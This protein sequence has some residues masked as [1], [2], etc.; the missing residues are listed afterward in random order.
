MVVY[1]K[2]GEFKA[3]VLELLQGVVKGCINFRVKDNLL[4]LQMKTV[5]ITELRM[6]VLR[7][8]HYEDRNLTVEI[9]RMVEVLS[10]DE[11]LSL[12]FV[13]DMIVFEQEGFSLTASKQPVELEQLDVWDKVFKDK[14]SSYTIQCVTNDCK[15]MDDV[16]KDLAMSPAPLNIIDGVCYVKYLTMAYTQNCSLPDMM[17]SNTAAKR[18]SKLLRESEVVYDYDETRGLLEIKQDQMSA[19][20]VSTMRPDH[21]EARL[22]NELLEDIESLTVL[23]IGKYKELIEMLGRIY[24]KVLVELTI[25]K[26]GLNVAIKNLGNKQLVLGQAAT[27]LCSI[28]ITMAQL[29]AI[30]KIFGRSSEETEVLKGGNLICLRNQH[31]GKN[32]MIAGT[33][34]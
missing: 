27:P 25:C 31:Y 6:Q 1:V 21:R 34:Y 19:C 10:D 9:D 30:A 24:K 22:I 7:V 20:V 33:L 23:N 26:G 28:T 2:A 17:I 5:E 14:M 8:E 3:R 32:L 16:A 13:G 12:T 29:V 15:C 4:Y 11:E 18:I